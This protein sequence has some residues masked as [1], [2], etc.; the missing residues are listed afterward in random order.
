MDQLVWGPPLWHILEDISWAAD[1]QDLD[2]YMGNKVLEFFHSLTLVLPCS[3]CRASYTQHF[4][5]NPIGPY[6]TG[7]KL[8]KW[9]W[10]L[11]KMVNDK[12]QKPNLDYD[13]LRKR[14]E[15]WTAASS[16]SSIWDVMF[17]V[18]YNI[19]S[20]PGE[21]M[22][23][24]LCGINEFI[25]SIPWLVGVLPREAPAEKWLLAQILLKDD[26]QPMGY[27]D[28]REFWLMWLW[29]KKL[30]YNQKIGCNFMSYDAMLDKYRLA[31]A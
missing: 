31:S 18:L 21:E 2:E 23:K 24:R 10:L 16:A 30:H 1:N 15:T 12:L 6:L 20:L 19:P 4:Q 7:K 28:L 14:M 26:V 22:D 25:S 3:I 13:R 27:S 17:I 5:T 8:L 11:H 9:V 29:G